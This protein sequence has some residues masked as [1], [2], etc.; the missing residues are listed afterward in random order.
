ME[1]NRIAYMSDARGFHALSL[2]GCH[3]SQWCTKY[4]VLERAKNRD[5]FNWTYDDLGQNS[6]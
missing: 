1:Q 4:E 2:P 6:D 3:L 5:D